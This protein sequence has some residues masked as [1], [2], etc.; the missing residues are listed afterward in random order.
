MDD[1]GLSHSIFVLLCESAEF[2]VEVEVNLKVQVP[3]VAEVWS[4]PENAKN[5]FALLGGYVVF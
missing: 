1:H 4:H 2:T 5:F 3:L